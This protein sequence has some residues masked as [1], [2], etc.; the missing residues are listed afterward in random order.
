MAKLQ[1]HTRPL[2]EKNA[3]NVNSECIAMIVYWSTLSTRLTIGRLSKNRSIKNGIWFLNEAGQTEDTSLEVR[4]MKI[5]QGVNKVEK[6]PRRRQA[7]VSHKKQPCW[8]YGYIGIHPEDNDC[9]VIRKKCS[10]C[11]FNHFSALC[12]ANTQQSEKRTTREYQTRPQENHRRSGRQFHQLWW[13]VI[14]PSS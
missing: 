10:K 7:T 4:G 13:W 3:T 2:C 11:H 1:R 6:Q 8:Y 14:L 9:S 5:L 12:P